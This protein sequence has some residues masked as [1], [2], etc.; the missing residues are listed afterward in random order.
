MTE[1]ISK[2]TSAGQSDSAYTTLVS[3]L[4]LYK[5]GSRHCLEKYVEPPKQTMGKK[6][7]ATTVEAIIGAVWLDSGKDIAVVKHTLHHLL[8][9]YIP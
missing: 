7:M 8:G 4:N 1:R 2:L 9:E 5:I 6:K 3:D